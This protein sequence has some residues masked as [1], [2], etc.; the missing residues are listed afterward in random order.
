MHCQVDLLGVLPAIETL[1]SRL[2]MSGSAFPLREPIGRLD[3]SDASVAQ[4]R[5][6]SKA[7]SKPAG[8]PRDWAESNDKCARA[9]NFGQ[10]SGTSDWTGLS[11]H[12]SRDVDWFKFQTLATAGADNYAAINF[13][14]DQGD[15]EIRLYSATGRCLRVVDSLGSNRI[16]LAGLPAGK[17]SIGI[18][19]IN[20][21]TNPSYS[22]EISAP[23]RAIAPAEKSS[24]DWTMLVYMAA[25][26]DLERYGILNIN[27]MESVALPAGV[28]VAVEMDRIAGFDKSN[29]NWTD[30]RRG[31]IVHDHKSG[32]ISSP[33]VSI[34]E[35]DMGS[36]DTLT[37]FIKWGV[38]TY[39]ADRYALVIWDHGGGLQG[40]CIDDTSGNL[41]SVAD[42]GQAIADSGK[43]PDLVGFDAC[44]E[45]IAEQQY[46]L[47]NVTDVVVASEAIV[48]LQ[49]WNYRGVLT[50]LITN[51]HM[52]AQQL[53]ACIVNTYGAFYHG[54]QTMAATRTDAYGGLAD[55]LTNFADAVIANAQ[56]SDWSAIDSARDAAA[57]FSTGSSRDLRTFM[58]G[59]AQTGVSAPIHESAQAVM[60]AI[61]AAVIANASGVDDGATGFSIFLPRLGSGA[62]EMEG[63]TSEAYS[64]LADTQWREFLDAFVSFTSQ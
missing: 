42:V 6:A 62:R 57:F 8:I 29:G 54:S 34:G 5:A 21:A 35:R 27:Q 1:E 23:A 16:S 40:V 55:S 3:S 46:Q 41:L 15:L 63:Y 18:C 56:P 7:S 50:G 58:A 48:P 25:D 26:N 47:R 30:T 19:G 33:M 59:V 22:V 32:V 36:P 53:G 11:I 37:D 52:D 9:Y 51:P 10:L 49:G 28:T 13:A 31:A 60:S 64:L 12:S 17:Y 44:L 39:P 43:R 14:A 45:G 4:M 2:L 24:R 38:N 61:D 20:H